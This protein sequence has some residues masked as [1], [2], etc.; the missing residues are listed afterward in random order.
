[1]LI[2][3]GLGRTF[4]NCYNDECDDDEVEREISPQVLIHPADTTCEPHSNFEDPSSFENTAVEDFAPTSCTRS[5]EE[6]QQEEEP[7]ASQFGPIGCQ[8]HRHVSQH[9]GGPLPQLAM[10]EPAYFYLL[11][12]YISY[13]ILI[14]FGKVRDFFGKRFKPEKY[15]NYAERN[16]YAALNSDFDN[17]FFR[18]LKTRMN[19]CFSRPYGNDHYPVLASY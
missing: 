7:I 17:F 3:P 11:T 5:A 15:K 13:F 8:S 4:Y 10:D 9:M 1:M 16:G 19:D 2:P 12:T 18:R 14:A 6:T